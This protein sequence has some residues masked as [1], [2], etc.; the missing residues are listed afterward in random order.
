MK[1]QLTQVLIGKQ[2]WG[3]RQTGNR[4]HTDVHFFIEA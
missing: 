3:R 1:F 2:L 4:Y